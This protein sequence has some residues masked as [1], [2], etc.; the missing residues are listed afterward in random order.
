[1]KCDTFLHYLSHFS[2]NESLA[3]KLQHFHKM[4]NAV[5]ILSQETKTKE[6]FA[7]E[8]LSCDIQISLFPLL[9]L[10][11]SCSALSISHAL[12]LCLSLFY[13]VT[14]SIQLNVCPLSLSF[15]ASFLFSFP[16]ILSISHFLSFLSHPVTSLIRITSPLP[17]PLSL[18]LFVCIF[19]ILIF[20]FNLCNN[21]GDR[22]CIISDSQLC[23][24]TEQSRRQNCPCRPSLRTP[25]KPASSFFENSALS[26]L[27]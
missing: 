13:S 8:S 3:L 26:I 12:F 6:R 25:P 15:S 19:P 7:E 20:S 4:Q 10:S 11:L 21:H 24:K 23:S 9:F 16:Y 1:M 17:L 2:Q 22:L 27:H 14:P 5:L 18:F